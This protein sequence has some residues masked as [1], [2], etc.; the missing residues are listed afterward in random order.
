MIRVSSGFETKTIEPNTEIAILFLGVT[1]PQESIDST[2]VAN[3][4]SIETVS[5]DGYPIDAAN[6]LAFSIGCI[7]PC[8]TCELGL[9]DWCTSC[10][11]LDNGTPLNFYK[12][13][14]NTG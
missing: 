1:N 14:V 7:F 10:L 3:Q 4:F 11:T 6:N 9:A 2:I 5:S 12:K 13:I 8:K